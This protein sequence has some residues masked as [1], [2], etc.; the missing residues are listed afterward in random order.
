VTGRYSRNPTPPQP[1]DR[2]RCNIQNIDITM[3][4]HN[5]LCPKHPSCLYSSS[6]LQ[7]LHQ[8]SCCYLCLHLDTLINSKHVEIKRVILQLSDLMLSSLALDGMKLK[9]WS[10]YTVQQ[11]NELQ[12]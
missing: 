8:F 7:T 1:E 11:N 5:W 10:Q 3:N 2:D 6:L 9:E 4:P 12:Y